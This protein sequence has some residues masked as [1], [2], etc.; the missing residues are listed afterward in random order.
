MINNLH[1]KWIEFSVS[2]KDFSKTEVKNKICI[3]IFVT[4]TNW[5]IRF[6]YY[7]KNFE[8][9]TDLLLISNENKSHFVYIKD[10]DRFMF[11]KAKSKNKKYFHKSC[12]QC[13]SDKNV[14]L[15]HKK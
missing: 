8:N 11:S 7:I 1:Y 4:K 9:S 2:K 3:N 6:T 5:L 14:L 12:L 10:F 15:E 13:F